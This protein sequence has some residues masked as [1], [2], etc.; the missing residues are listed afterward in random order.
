MSLTSTVSALHNIVINMA[1]MSDQNMLSGPGLGRHIF[2]LSPELSSAQ[3]PT[4]SII[5]RC[6]RQRQ[7]PQSAC[8]TSSYS[9][10]ANSSFENYFHFYF[11]NFAAISQIPS[12]EV[13]FLAECKHLECQFLLHK[14]VLKEGLSN[15]DVS[16][17]AT[18]PNQILD[19]M[20][21]IT[22]IKSGPSRS[23]W[24]PCLTL[25]CRTHLVFPSTALMEP[26]C[27]AAPLHPYWYCLMQHTDVILSIHFKI[28]KVWL[29]AEHMYS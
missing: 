1:C 24:R 4:N 23:W 27:S 7:P 29:D 28:M 5:G 22:K 13:N 21:W 25:Q 11:R 14:A 2:H 8:R 18:G 12:I 17:I 20:F 26:I 16:E 19:I 6:R 3:V 15:D 9:W 10:W